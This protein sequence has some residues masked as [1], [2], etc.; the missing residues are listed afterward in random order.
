MTLEQAGEITAEY[1]KD[2][3]EAAKNVSITS[4]EAVAIL[5]QE[6]NY[7]E[8]MLGYAKR[9]GSDYE[10]EA[11]MCEAYKMAMEALSRPQ[12]NPFKVVYDFLSTYV[13][14]CDSEWVDHPADY[15]IGILKA[16]A[17]VKAEWEE[18]ERS[19]TAENTTDTI[20]VEQ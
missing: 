20:E 13:F 10:E 2:E 18:Q 16:I 5:Q 8:S 1:L 9:V 17:V 11:R 6:C 14:P 7:Y 4:S 12:E 15:Y 3:Q 19:E